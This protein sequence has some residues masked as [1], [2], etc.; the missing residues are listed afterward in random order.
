MR[1]TFF[2]PAGLRKFRK[3]KKV[4]EANRLAKRTVYL[5]LVLQIGFRCTRIGLVGD[6]LTSWINS[7]SMFLTIL[8]CICLELV[9]EGALLV[10][11]LVPS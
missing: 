2:L 3:F 10:H 1:H 11:P 8:E 7:T 4:T 6:Q 5:K 9:S